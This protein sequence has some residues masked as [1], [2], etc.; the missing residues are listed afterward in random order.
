MIPPSGRTT[1]LLHHFVAYAVR[2]AQT[3]VPWTV[4]HRPKSMKSSTWNTVRRTCHK[5]QKL[6]A[7]DFSKSYFSFAPSPQCLSGKSGGCGREKQVASVWKHSVSRTGTGASCEEKI[8]KSTVQKLSTSDTPGRHRDSHTGYARR[9]S[10]AS[11]KLAVHESASALGSSSTFCC[12]A[13]RLECGSTPHLTSCETV[14]S[15][16]IRVMKSG[17]KHR[18]QHAV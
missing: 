10:M 8:V 6:A 17:K 16:N 15:P 7:I 14:R 18:R 4:L 2:V 11:P 1:E 13:H 9:Q 12:V 5:T 3:V